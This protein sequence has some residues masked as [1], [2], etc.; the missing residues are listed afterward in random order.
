MNSSDVLTRSFA[1]V[2]PCM[3]EYLAASRDWNVGISIVP[4]Q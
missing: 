2:A 3:P 1:Y 4:A